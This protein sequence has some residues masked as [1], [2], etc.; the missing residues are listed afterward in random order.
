MCSSDLTFARFDLFAPGPA[1]CAA[2]SG[3]TESV[4]SGN[5]LDPQSTAKCCACN[6][7]ALRE[8]CQ[9]PSMS[10][11]KNALR[12]FRFNISFQIISSR[13]RFKRHKVAGWPFQAVSGC[14]RRSTGLPGSLA[15]IPRLDQDRVSELLRRTGARGI[16]NL[17]ITS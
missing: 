4:P 17:G 15:C 7:C 12:R 8:R 14:G 16:N 9:R 5:R 13:S 2:E 6:S 10:F 11:G 3:R 1:H